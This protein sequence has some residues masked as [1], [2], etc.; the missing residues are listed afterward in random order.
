VF[1]IAGTDLVGAVPERLA[2]RVSAAAGVVVIDPPFGPVEFV[3]A[4]WWHPLHATDMGLTWLRG[5]VTEV[6]AA[7]GHAP[8]LPGQRR[9]AEAT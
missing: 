2:R 9:A 6:A 7:F 3:E 1:L 5:V 8:V 4:A